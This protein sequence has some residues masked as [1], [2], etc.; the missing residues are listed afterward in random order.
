[1]KFTFNERKEGKLWEENAEKWMRAKISYKL[2]IPKNSHYGTSHENL[3][4]LITTKCQ[5]MEK[6]FARNQSWTGGW[7]TRRDFVMSVNY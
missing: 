6:T 4:T 2:I 5:I 1:M 7:K 3:T